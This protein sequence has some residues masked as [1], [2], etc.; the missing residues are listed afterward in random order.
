MC[1]SKTTF[2][3][4]AMLSLMTAMILSGGCSKPP[5]DTKA[6]AAVPSVQ[7]VQG[8]QLGDLS[9]FKSIAQDVA[10]R[11]AEN[12]LPGA[13]TRIKDLE[14]SWDEAEAGIKPRAASDWHRLDKAIDKA[15]DALRANSPAQS[16]CEAAMTNLLSTFSDLEGKH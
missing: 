5:S 2:N 7:A 9:G 1:L 15:L 13:K 4:V 16:D 14:L 8:T 11:V 10:R 12:D 3:R 6:A